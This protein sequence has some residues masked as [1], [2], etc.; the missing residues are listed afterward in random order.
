MAILRERASGRKNCWEGENTGECSVG[1]TVTLFH[2]T[3][4]GCG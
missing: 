3:V 4:A 2:A 1:A